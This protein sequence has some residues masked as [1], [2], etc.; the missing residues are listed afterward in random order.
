MYKQSAKQKNEFA[1]KNYDRIAVVIKKGEREKIR[2]R[3]EALGLSLNGYINKLIDEDM[4]K[5]R[6]I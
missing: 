4:K 6:S 2:V 5:E 1:K 3:A